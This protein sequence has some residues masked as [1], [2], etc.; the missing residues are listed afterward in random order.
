[1]SYN[2]T[3][4]ELRKKRKKNETANSESPLN[5]AVPFNTISQGREN[6]VTPFRA[7]RQ[8]IISPD[9]NFI[10]P[11]KTQKQKSN[12]VN[13]QEKEF[14]ETTAFEDTLMQKY[15]VMSLSD[16]EKEYKRV[17]AEEKAFKEANNGKVMNLLAKLGSY[18]I[19]ENNRVSGS[20]IRKEADANLDKINNFTKEKEIINKYRKQKATEEYLGKLSKEQ[21]KLID[22]IIDRGYSQN[23]YQFAPIITPE[24]SGHMVEESAKNSE[25][26]NNLKKNFA[27]QLKKQYKGKSDDEINELVDNIVELR[28]NQ[29]NAQQQAKD[30]AEMKK[31]ASEHGVSA[32]LLSRGANILGGFTGLLEPVLQAGNEYGIDEN[33]GGFALTNASNTIDEQIQLDHDWKVNVGNK[34]VDGF[35]LMYAAGTSILD[36]IART[37]LSGGNNTIASGI[38][39]SQVFTQTLINDKE[40]GYSDAKALTIALITATIESIG[41]KLAFDK[42]FRSNGTILK[43]AGK[44]FFPEGTQEAATNWINKIA[45]QI[46]N[47]NQSELSRQYTLYLENGYTESEALAEVVASSIGDD[48]EA[49]LIGGL[50]GAVLGG[51]NA[52]IKNVSKNTFTETEQKVIDKEIENRIAEKEK[53]GSTVTSKEKSQIRKSVINDL[54]KGYI[55]IDT[56][57]EALGGDTYKSYKEAVDNE[58]ALKEEFNTLNQ[59]KQG[60]MT[61]EQIDRRAEI[62]QQLEELKNNSNT[63][64]LKQQLSDDVFGIAKDSRLAESYNEKTRRGQTFEADLSKYDAKQQEVIKKA[65]ES[66]ILNNTNRTHEFVDMLARVSAD[67]GVSFDFTNNEKLKNS[68]FA[69]EGS[70][71][72]GYIQGNN[73]TL[74]IDSAKALN[75]VVGHEIT[76]ILEGTELY[77]SLQQTIIKYAKSKGDYQGRYDTLSKL[78]E[79][80][81]GANIDNE[82][83]ADLV[84]DYL[85]TDSE[86]INSLSTEQPNL[87][88]RIYNE[89]KYLYKVATAGSKEARELEKVKRVFEKA[90]KESAN[91]KA[92]TKTGGKYSLS[93]SDDYSRIQQM[94]LELNETRNKI[95]EIEKSED[96][97]SKMAKLTEA[98]SNDDVNNAIKEYKSWQEVSGYGELIIRK[99]TLQTELEKTR[100][101][102]SE[103]LANAEV[104]KERIAIEKSGLSEA[105]YF[106]KQ[107][108]K[109]FGY[110]PYF[111]DAGYITPNGKMLNFSGEKG[112]HFGSRGQDH[113]AIGTIFA[114]TQGTDALN[115]FMKDGNIRIIAESPAVD[116]SALVEPTK[117]QYSTIRKFIYQYAEKGYFAVDFSDENGIVVGSLG[118]ENNINPARIINDI[119]HF[120]E[121]GEIREQS[122]TD[123]FRYSLSEDSKDRVFYTPFGVEVVQNPTSAE[124]LQMREDIYN[125][126]PHLRGT[127]EAILRQTYDEEGN[128]YYWS[129][130]DGM[131]RSVEPYIN[132][133]YN[134]RTSQHWEWWKEKNKDDIPINYSNVRYSLSPAEL[135]K[136]YLS[137]V[138]NNDMK[139]AQRMVEEAVE[140]SMPDSK[141]RDNKG[142]LKLVYHGRVSEF[143]VF[144]REYSNIEGDFGKGFYFTDNE[145][146]VDR[147]YANVDGQDLTNKIERYADRL[148]AEDGLSRSEAYDKAYEKY[149][150]GE[151]N[152]VTAYLNIKNPV[153][154]TP[155]EKGTF[156]DF[157]NG[158]DAETDTYYDASGEF[159]EFVDALN[160]F[161]ENYDWSGNF[162]FDFLYEYAYD[163][164][165]M[166]A[167]DA[168]NV[169]KKRVL[170]ELVDENGDIA[171]N[172]I[173]RLAFEEIGYDGIIDSSVGYK[174]GHMPYMT[175]D[176]THYIVFNSN[177]IKSADLV[178]Y[179]DNGNVIPLSKRF[180]ADNNDIR[181]SYSKEGQKP[182]EYG[183]FNIYGKD[184]KYQGTED[185]APVQK[186]VAE[187]E[188]I[189]PVQTTKQVDVKNATTTIPEDYAPLTEEQATEMFKNDR[190]RFNSLDDTDAPPEITHPPYYSA[191]T[192]RLDQKTLNNISAILKEQLT[193]NKAETKAIQDIV[194]KYSTAEFPSKADLF[195]EIKARFGEKAWKERNESIADVKQALR[196]TRLYVSPTIKSDIADYSDFMRRNFGKIRFAK[197]G[198]PVDTAYMELSAEYPDYFPADITNAT[199]QLLKMTEIAN[200]DINEFLTEVLD[201]ET[202]Q[203][204]T[205]IIADIVSTTKEA[206]IIKQ[207]Q[208]EAEEFYNQLSR[209]NKAIAP[210]I[211]VD[212]QTE[213]ANKGTKENGTKEK[214]AEILTE[215]PKVK[216]KKGRALSRFGI[217]FIDKALPVETLAL[218]TGNRELDAKYNS[219]RYAESKAQNLIGKGA[220]GVK[221]L[222]DIQAEV[223]SEGLTASL[224]EYLYHK[225]NVDRMSLESRDASNIAKLHELKLDTLDEKQLYAIAKEKITE[226]TSEK[227]ANVIN[228]VRD[229][230]AFKGAKNKAVFGDSVTA[231]MSQAVVDKYER[232]NPKLI[233]YAEDVY[234]YNRYLR[235]LLVENGI[236]SQETADLW[237]KI[238]PHY[239]PIRRVGNEGLNIN[240]P[241]D[242]GRTGV[243]APIKKATGGNS[244]ILPLFDTMGNRT[245]QTYKAIAKNRFG[246]EL[247]NTLGTT[248]ENTDTSLDDVIDSIDTQDSLLQEGKNGKNPTFTVFENGE[249]VTF[250]ITEELYDAMKPT[251]EGLAYTNPVANK[252]TNAMR[253]VLTEYN[254]TFMFTNAIKDAQDV[255]INS[256]HPAS[257]YKNFPKAIMELTKKSGKWY[258]EYMENGG[259]ENT[260]FE[261]QTNTFAAEK[262]EIS[263]VIGFPLEKI[264]D[265]N[266]FIEKI[267]RLAE[268]IASREVGR[269]V[270]V[271]ML[272][273]ARVT[274][275]FSAGGDVTKFLNRNGATFL[276]ASVQGAVQ[277]ARNVREAKYNGLKGWVQLASKIALAG[278]PAMLLNGLLWD[279]DE[280]YEELS[281]YVKDNYYIVGKMQDGTFVRIPKGRATAVIQNAF[282]Q[283]SNALTGDDE[284]DLGRFLELAVSNL[285]PNNPLDNNI[286]APIIQVAKNKTWYGEDL[287]P[288]RLQDVPKEE[289]YDEST[290]AISK[291]L[292]ENL[293]I[294]PYKINYL[295]NQY[296]GGVGDVV[297]PMLTPKAERGDNSFGG[298]LLAP[299]KDKFTTDSVMKNQSVSDFYNTSDKLKVNA[300]SSKATDEDVLKNKY[301]NAIQSELGELYAEKRAIQNS[302][303]D[304][305]NKYQQVREIQQEIN[306]LARKALN[307]YENVN[308]NGNYANIGDIHYHL[309]DKNEWI[310]VDNKQFEKQEEATK[311]LGI[312]P[313]EYWG[314][315][316]EYDFAYKSPEKYAL[317][318]A[319]GG[320]D[321]Y[322]TYSSDL[323]DIHADKDENGKSINGSRKEKVLDYINNLDAD[324]YEKIILFKSEY[325]ADDTYNNEIIDY[326][327]EREDISYKEMVAILKELGFNVDSKGN[328]SW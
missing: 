165:G 161:A 218:K 296:S 327:N 180:N 47:G 237:E 59:M 257:T 254:P 24:I 189:A 101:E 99:N 109:E 247:K 114:D 105:D 26:I 276:N 255:L 269:S 98:I 117:E 192:T 145:G 293:N 196:N 261:K 262:S 310:K 68:S 44:S 236:I 53:D 135:D 204:A 64:Q 14:K 87:F 61:G 197:D 122:N 299:L 21:I 219:I 291:W 16:I 208:A 152:T 34:E 30:D 244:D 230:F 250:E 270:D 31:L 144:D 288:S 238:Y 233:E 20:A 166:Y 241:L 245:L 283:I 246:V 55:S 123:K 272:D 138:K 93:D 58:N 5:R 11:I 115:R 4:Q 103:K 120:Y 27:T 171:V 45:D 242:T 70:T 141:V 318:K 66:G 163:N 199:D 25:Q 292:G 136:Q 77:N 17:E 79:G 175:T 186:T 56:I 227:R 160:Y 148:E 46:A 316:A 184:I 65:T 251:S 9:P 325:N 271:A 90:Y 75:S 249:K 173:I 326:L 73:V 118:Y 39:N 36:Q 95:A 172:E 194:Q 80:V 256:Q 308:I 224:Y 306:R 38:L 86:F 289:Q 52:A 167:S 143:N 260:Y 215:E 202:I 268:Y 150:L 302:D 49:F 159:V 221:A 112:R 181:Y 50:T 29:V 319:V 301:F 281:N 22:E 168:V 212:K 154:I 266:N 243:N 74:N 81:E 187:Q 285:A 164:M 190:E 313:D 40:K 209:E 1:M 108:V 226:K 6:K 3:Y 322:K 106:R 140:K 133:H 60:E 132:K 149:I 151:E 156:L 134:T 88:K 191:D 267:P 41:N 8:Q 131:H 273:A 205:D 33:A 294:S 248:I 48:F 297:L 274:T 228:A 307:T 102:Y 284:V 169:I 71:V 142:N 303:L 239:I 157:D 170:D 28:R 57:E 321:A 207:S 220:E 177:Q 10:A 198:L 324:Y 258:N 234:N 300:N 124:Y 314:N 83:T 67:K 311:S 85:F 176:T 96:F 182:K 72:N 206:N 19:G 259:A 178:T 278:L 147:N 63:S 280:D 153:Y 183:N 54:E 51:G 263:K 15:S 174:F 210:V 305:K 298:N 290:D 100:K 69:V 94:Q 116:V 146:D 195:N 286:V 304:D 229:Y 92:D 84:G 252:I 309:N 155:D 328:I 317:A 225:H 42:I 231:E 126:Y 130:Y 97:K 323:Y 193:L 35:D 111:Y 216:K 315:K 214:V 62:K 158:Y 104:E 240:V 76:H 287:V 265:A 179:D 107:A 127:G 320:Y 129:A 12:T 277:Q 18:T 279:D 211:N 128:V 82:L 217:N 91:T 253:G 312:T 232:E 121:T 13:T 113:R 223:E 37:A 78:Y 32:F 139:T 188:A 162:N 235:N 185:V 125:A 201:D 200:M 119:K 23:Y 213:N 203:E 137:A 282:E 275:N 2:S 89:I 7:I 264:S 295:L 110:T 43:S 222:T